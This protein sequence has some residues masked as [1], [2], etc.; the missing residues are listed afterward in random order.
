[1]GK[2]IFKD[3]KFSGSEKISLPKKIGK[4][5]ANYIS[6]YSSGDQEIDAYNN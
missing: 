5:F 2:F 6:Q 1:M 4:L 3:K